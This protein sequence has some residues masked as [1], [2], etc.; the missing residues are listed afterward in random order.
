MMISLSLLAFTVNGFAQDEVTVKG[1][2]AFIDLTK[3]IFVVTTHDRK[4]ITIAID[5]GALKKFEKGVI[6]EG[7][8]V[9]VKCIVQN[10][11]LKAVSFFRKPL[12]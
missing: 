5:D 7:D 8:D 4:E 10:E 11:R 6:K 3:K 9:T 12:G 1:T 2:V